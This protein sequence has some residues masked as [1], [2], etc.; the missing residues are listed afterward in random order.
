M[1]KRIIKKL[2]FK[3]RSDSQAFV[4]HLRK[5]GAKIGERVIVFEPRYTIIDMTRPWLLDIGDD[6]Q[7]TYGVTILTHGYDWSVLKGVYGEVLGSSG[8]VKIGNN[9]FIGMHSTILKGVTIGDNVIIGANSLVNK[10]VESGWVVAGNP[11]K[12]I[13][14]IEEYYEKRKER[15]LAEAKE[16]YDF[17]VRQYHK[18]PEKR[19]FSEFFWLFEERKEP[20]YEPFTEKLKLLGN[21]E[22][23]LQNF[24]NSTPLFAGY[25]AFLEYLRTNDN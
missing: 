21:Y 22:E 3:Y 2:L 17:Y 9:V 16:L 8:K 11:A 23:T 13:M 7:I 19:V 20:I 5:I 14:R 1:I 12:P 6:V 10:D 4:E 18:E 24:M 15:Q 25:D